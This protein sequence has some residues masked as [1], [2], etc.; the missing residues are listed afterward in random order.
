MMAHV[1]K[2]SSGRQW[3]YFSWCQSPLSELAAEL[4]SLPW[5]V[6]TIPTPTPTLLELLE[7]LTLG[8]SSALVGSSQFL[9]LRILKGWPWWGPNCSPSPGGDRWAGRR[10]WPSWVAWRSLE[11]LSLGCPGCVR[12]QR[13]AHGE[14]L[15]WEESRRMDKVADWCWDNGI[16]SAKSSTIC[17]NTKNVVGYS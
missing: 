5:R 1:R 10:R 14:E 6:L 13:R 2:L 3:G 12:R 15:D 8:I 9:S 7:P 17:F 4:L 11:G 16:A